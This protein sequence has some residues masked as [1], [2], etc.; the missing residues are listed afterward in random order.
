MAPSGPAEDLSSTLFGFQYLLL[1]VFS[2]LLFAGAGQVSGGQILPSLKLAHSP[3]TI[4]ASR[5]ALLSSELLL[6]CMVPFHLGDHPH[7]HA[8]SCAS[9][10]CVLV[11]VETKSTMSRD[12]PAK[13]VH[14]I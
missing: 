1:H 13:F 5:K 4:T 3:I 2:I 12:V 6:F 11:Q 10:S 7:Q 9:L 8:R 14:E